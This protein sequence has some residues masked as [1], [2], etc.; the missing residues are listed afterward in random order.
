MLVAL[1]S[2]IDIVRYYAPSVY[3]NAYYIS[4]L[5][6]IGCLAPVCLRLASSQYISL[7]FTTKLVQGVDLHSVCKK[8]Q[9]T[10]Y[11]KKDLKCVICHRLLSVVRRL[12]LL[13]SHVST[14]VHSISNFTLR[15][16]H[17]ILMRLAED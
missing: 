12:Y 13:S 15:S 8:P 2:L 7:E 5:L 10:S 16:I 1:H 6:L 14:L 9:A 11:R 4:K 3:S 17:F